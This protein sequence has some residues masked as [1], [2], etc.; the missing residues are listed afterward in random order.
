MY[1]K[2]ILY[3]KKTRLKLS[4]NLTAYNNK[5]TKLTKNKYNLFLKL[6]KKLTVEISLMNQIIKVTFFKVHKIK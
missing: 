2:L 1:N 5:S 3:L 6:M 4:K